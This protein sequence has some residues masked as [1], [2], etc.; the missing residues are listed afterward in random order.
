LNS[1]LNQ[2]TSGF[3]GGIVVWRMEVKEKTGDTKVINKV[4]LLCGF[5]SLIMIL[6]SCKLYGDSS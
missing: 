4:I 6:V 2:T 3:A 1:K 5:Y